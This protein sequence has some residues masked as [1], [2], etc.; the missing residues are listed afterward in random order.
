[1]DHALDLAKEAHRLLLTGA[2]GLI[3]QDAKVG[4]DAHAGL[5]IPE[6]DGPVVAGAQRGRH[7]ACKSRG[8]RTWN[9][10]SVPD[11]AR[12]DRAGT[13]LLSVAIADGNL[14]F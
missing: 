12:L 2:G 3:N 1:M 4:E 7:L 10:L 14:P 13:V 6:L 9:G 11:F 8:N 5:G